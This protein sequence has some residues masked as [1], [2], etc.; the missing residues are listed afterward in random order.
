MGRLLDLSRRASGISDSAPRHEINEK[1][2]GSDTPAPDRS[3]SF[4][5]QGPANFWGVHGDH[6]GWRLN[7]VIEFMDGLDYP[8]GLIC[9]LEAAAPYLYDRLTRALPERISRAWGA[10]VPFNEFDAL[11]LELE[12]THA[13]AVA[14]F[15]QHLVSRRRAHGE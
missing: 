6:Y 11:C 2:V 15:R 12:E 13:R 14:L 8:A 9:W 4:T 1:R 5:T 10:K 7:S 3:A